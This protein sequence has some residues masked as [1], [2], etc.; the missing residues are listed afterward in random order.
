MEPTSEELN[1]DVSIEEDGPSARKLTITVP[2]DV[3]DERIENAYG[4]LQMQAQL[5]GF[6]KGKAP[7]QLLE[8]RFGTQVIDEARGQLIMGAY[9]Q[10]VATNELK[11]VGEPEFDESLVEKNLERGTEFAFE[12]SVDVVPEFEMPVLEKVKIQK[13]IFEVEESHIDEE[14]DRLRYRFGTPEQVTEGFQPMDRVVGKAVVDVED[15]EGTFF[16]TDKALA[17]YPPEED[18]TSGPVLG[19]LIEDLASTLKGAKLGDELVLETVGPPT[20]ERSELRDKKVTIRLRVEDGER[21]TPLDADTLPATLGL[22]DEKMLRERIRLETESRRDQEQRSAE[23]E[24]VFEYLLD[25]TTLELPKR[26]SE[27]QV[28]R[29]IERQRMELLY[30]GEDPEAVERQLAEMREQTEEQAV[31]RLKLMFI[32][33]RIA[34]HFDIQVTEQEINGRIAMIAQ[35]RGERPDAVRTELQKSGGLQ[36]VARQ[37]AEHKAADRIVD[38]A[39]V[40]EIPAEEWNR[41]AEE[42]RASRAGGAA[43]SGSSGAKKSAGKKTASKKTGSKKGSD[44]KTA[45][46]TTKKTAKKAGKKSTKKTGKKK[47]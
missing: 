30:R 4:T 32:M 15:H 14:I 45:K 26:I 35:Q 20:H 2:S 47:S 21:I 18:G 28:A 41:K 40:S 24:Q 5:P 43:S 34:R 17:I 37:I 13:P 10:A 8:K 7:R 3:V 29:S 42:R 27:A 22:E 44:E 25:N 11:V 36:E 33:D 19:L 1:I 46:K 39:T 12:V 23:R 9:Q 31:N 16:E 38:Q 6:R